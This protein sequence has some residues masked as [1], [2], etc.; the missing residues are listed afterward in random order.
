MVHEEE[1]A[2]KH[3]LLNTGRIHSLD[4]IPDYKA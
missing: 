3:K 2:G 1:N 4:D